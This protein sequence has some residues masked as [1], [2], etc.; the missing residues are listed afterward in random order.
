MNF[1]SKE[2]CIKSESILYCIWVIVFYVSDFFYSYPDSKRKKSS[3]GL[4]S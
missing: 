2:K 3:D 4:A 1:L